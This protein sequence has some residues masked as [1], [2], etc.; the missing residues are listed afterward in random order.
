MQSVLKI[1]FT[2]V[3]YPLLKE[4]AVWIYQKY[5]ENKTD[6]QRI[7]YLEQK[8][9]LKNAIKNAKTDEEIKQ[10]SIVLHNLARLN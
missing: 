2:S 8:R 1:L 7:K 3:L 10:L 4:G 5:M 6:N 9:A